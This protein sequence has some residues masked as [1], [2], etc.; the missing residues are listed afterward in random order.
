MLATRVPVTPF[1]ER[2]EAP[3]N[4]LMSL[5][6][7][8]EFFAPP[9]LMIRLFGYYVP[10]ITLV[11]GL[12]DFPLFCGAF[13]LG[14][15][16]RF[17]GTLPEDIKPVE[18]FV[19]GV[20]FGAI[21]SLSVMSVGIYRGNAYNRD[22]GFVLRLSLAC[23]IGSGLL[24]QSLFLFPSLTVGR[25]V[26]ALSILFAFV[27]V[28]LLREIVIRVADPS[29]HRR[30]VLVVGAGAEARKIAELLER[31]PGLGFVTVG[32]APLSDCRPVIA[33]DKLLVS[34]GSLLD[35]AIANRVDEVVVAADD[36]RQALPMGELLDCRMHGFPIFDLFTF[37]ER[38]LAL[39]KVDLLTPSLFT[40]SETGFR[41]GLTG[42]YGKRLFDLV[43]ASIL[44][45]MAAPIMLVVGFASLIE[46]RGKNPILYHQARVGLGGKTFRI[47]KFR[48]MR[49]NAEG[50][51][52]PRWA[53][54]NDP[55]ITRL[56][57]FLRLTR[58]DEIPQ[59][60]NVI[61]GEMSLVGPRPERPEFVEQLSAAIPFYAERHRVKPGLTG[62]AQLN[63]PY[64]SGV[65]DAKCKLEFD[66]YYV[67]HA[68][69]MFDFVIL[70]Q[71]VEVVLFAKGAR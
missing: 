46:S 8:P 68:S 50:D 10:G 26:G 34:G 54:A 39:I 25:G 65:E 43:V 14:V 44:L 32:Y 63:Y 49:T 22:Q 4:W 12:L 53:C 61:K 62:W 52:K 6:M 13:Y 36:N 9:N 29:T 42:L 47:H 37:F 58:L 20:I 28:L 2:E 1:D 57:M 41:A 35:L 45:V 3:L 16:I 66:L 17:G 24:A 55:R 21:M 56:G 27:G 71:T 60:F 7:Q 64:G 70:V 38:E 67:K 51:G 19:T 11:R 30:R 23:V 40:L 31:R 18:M 59:L 33:P 15:L 48:S 5:P 69:I